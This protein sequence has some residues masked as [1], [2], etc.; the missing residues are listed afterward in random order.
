MLKETVEQSSVY[1]NYFTCNIN[2]FIIPYR[3]NEKLWRKI[4]NSLVFKFTGYHLHRNWSPSA[5]LQ[6]LL[7]EGMLSWIMTV[8]GLAPLKRHSFALP[9][10]CKWTNSRSGPL[11]VIQVELFSLEGCNF[12]PQWP[13]W[14]CRLCSLKWSTKRSWRHDPYWCQGMWSVVGTTPQI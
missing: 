10:I 8:H 12:Y 11:P 5:S 3:Y 2:D 13:A 1:K 7:M 4:L 9:I 6:H 14:T